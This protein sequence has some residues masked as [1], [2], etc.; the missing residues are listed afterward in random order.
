MVSAGMMDDIIGMIYLSLLLM[1]SHGSNGSMAIFP[2]KLAIFI[3]ATAFLTQLVPVILMQFEKKGRE[4]AMFNV[5]ILVALV[6]AILSEIAGLSAIV[7]AFLAG[8][9]LQKSFTLKRNEKYEEHEIEIFLFGFI[10]PFFFI[11]IA[12]NFDYFSLLEAPLLTLFVIGL[13]IA[14]KM[15][16]VFMARL[17]VKL[18]WKQLT[19][20]GWAMNS[21]GVV[22]LVV[23]EI[24]LRGGL[25]DQRLYSAIV[26]M[27]ITTSLLSLFFMR[28]MIEKD[29]KIM[30]GL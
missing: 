30:N 22:E 16:G 26:L 19:L 1:I 10:I 15:I 12:L 25:I 29:S 20:L 14:G 28:N 11:N 2:L 9:I 5:V 4:V 21:R 17:F 18:R 27:A 3:G 23:A 24:A 8:M 6:F 13:A 7:G